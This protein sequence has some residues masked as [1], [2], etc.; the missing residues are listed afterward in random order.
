MKKKLSAL[1]CLALTAV[2]SLNACTRLF[3]Q[4]ENDAFLKFTA[5]L[6]RQEVSSSAIT[7]HYTLK[8]PEKYG[9][10]N[11]PVTLG[12]YTADP[13]ALSASCENTLAVLDSFRRQKLSRENR[14]TYDVL[15]SYL[16]ESLHAVPFALY[17][18]PLSPLTGVQSQLPLLLSE[19]PFYSDEDIDSYLAL[20]S[21][22]PEHFASLIAF[23]KEKSKAG[24]FMSSRCAQ[25]I[26]EE[27]SSFASMGD[28]HYLFSSFQER[29]ETVPDLSKQQKEAYISQ[30]QKLVNEN[31]F[32][33][34]RKLSAAMAALKNTGKNQNGLCYYPNGKA[35]YE[36]IV[37]RDTGSS[38]SVSDLQDLTKSQMAEDLTAMQSALI[39]SSKTGESSG[40]ST[41]KLT[42]ENT[43]PLV[44]LDSLKEKCSGDFP[45]LP[46]VNIQVK[47]VQAEMED[48]LSPA[49]FMVPAIDDT[50][51][52]VIYINE[53]HL[54]D[55][56]TLY[57][58]L[59]HEGYPGHLYQNVYYASTNPDPIRN[60]LD[61]G[62]YT[63]GW[64]TYVE[65]ISYY[66]SALD[67]QQ[68]VLAQR[69]ASVILGLYALADMGIHYDGWSLAETV[70]FFRNFGITDTQTIQDIY[71]LILG[72]P[73]NYLK[74]YIGYVEF[75]ELK[76]TAIEK[77]GDSFTQERFHK[78]VLDTGPAPF[79]IVEKYALGE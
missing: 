63:E 59:A 12:A 58:T 31:I 66:Y 18:E 15:R 70:S 54:P 9:V 45:A 47:Q 8:Y 72:D 40:G 57:T 14:L 71:D 19:Y 21:D 48:Y 20:I 39:K 22:V 74:Y 73:G 55:D 46:D 26:I 42:L 61:W 50:D 24:L 44:I 25:D 33:S 7:L 43:D 52:N 69:N 17:E 35:Y 49:F 11:T 38:R 76:K 36:Y 79:E 30:H 65:M 75:L 4:D 5:D 78:A 32:P 53:G 16:T 13:T 41:V 64:A 77:W 6:F 56:L 37:R 67:T 1:L 2:I 23:E 60:L 27:C 28:S 51:D 3:S 10:E 62:G 34:Y 68:A 29:L